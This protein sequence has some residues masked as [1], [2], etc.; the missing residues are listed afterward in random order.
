MDDGTH[1]ERALV[2]QERGEGRG[3]NGVGER[4]N[5]GSVK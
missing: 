2:Q 1:T 4:E 5:I 3:N